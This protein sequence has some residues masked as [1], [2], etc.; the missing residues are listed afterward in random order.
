[1]GERRDV[2]RILVGKTKGKGPLGAPTYRWENNINMDHQEVG[3]GGM[4]WIS[5][6][7]DRDRWQA[8][9]N[10]GNEPSGSIKCREFF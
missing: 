4:D 9:L 7:Q 10:I 5:V 2:Y 1:M 8:L 6:A 3:W